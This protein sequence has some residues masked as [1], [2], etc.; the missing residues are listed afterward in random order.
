MINL[1]K[2]KL[3]PAYA[4]VFFLTIQSLQVNNSNT[5]TLHAVIISQ[6]SLI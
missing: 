4:L 5:V 1:Q 6:R 3:S 2:F